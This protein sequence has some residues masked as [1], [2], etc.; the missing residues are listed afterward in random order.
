MVTQKKQTSK[1]RKSRA[2]VSSPYKVENDFKNAAL[3]VSVT[4]NLA[5]FVG[6]LA[7][8]LSSQFDQEVAVM[9]FTR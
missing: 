1:S 5:V 7:I 2:S 4:I 8:K 9:L 3:V 6:W